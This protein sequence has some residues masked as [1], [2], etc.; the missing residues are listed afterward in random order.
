[1][2]AIK[3]TKLEKFAVLSGV[4]TALI[5]LVSLFGWLTGLRFLTSL[6]VNFIPISLIS[7]VAFFL[8]GIILVCLAGKIFSD[9]LHYIISALLFMVLMCGLVILFGIS[10]KLFP[11]PE[12]K[13]RLSGIVFIVNSVAFL[14]INRIRGNKY[15]NDFISMAGM[16]TAFIGFAVI[17][18]CLFDSPIMYSGETFPISLNRGLCDLFLGLGMI[19]LGGDKTLILKHLSGDGVNA[20]I[21][22]IIIPFA[23]FGVVI[24]SILFILIKQTNLDFA[25]TAAFEIVIFV[26]ICIYLG[27]WL[28]RK[29]FIDAE[30]AEKEKKLALE[31]LHSAEDKYLRIFNVSPVP[32]MITRMKDGRFIDVN[33]ATAELMGLKKEY[34]IGKTSLELGVYA[35]PEDRRKIVEQ[36][37]KS[38]SAFGVEVRQKIPNGREILLRQNYQVFELEGEKCILTISEDIT[39]T[40]KTE[41][42]I[43]RLNADLEQRNLWLEELNEMTSGIN[44]LTPGSD[45][46]E[47]VTGKLIER[48]E[49]G[50]VLFSSYDAGKKTLIVS[51]YKFR[52]SGMLETVIKIL[53]NKPNEVVT[54]VSDEQYKIITG[55]TVVKHDS[56]TELSFGGV[57]S[58]VS[59]GIKK[60]LGLDCFITLACFNDNELFGCSI[61][62]IKTGSE[63]PSVS[64][65]EALANIIAVALRRERAQKA[66]IE[67]EKKYRTLV[68]TTPG[69]IWSIDADARTMFVNES[70]ANMLGYQ[71][72]EML[73]K[74]LYDFMDEE[75]RKLAKIHM[76]RRIHGIREQHD[77]EFTRKDG[78]KIYTSLESTPLKDEKGK[79]IGALAVVT[80]LTIRKSLEGKLIQAQKLDAI[81]QLASGVSH[82]FNNLLTIISLAMEEAKRKNTLE[83]Y[84]K[85]SETVIK[86]SKQA[87]LIAKRLNEFAKKRA[88][89]YR[90]QTVVSIVDYV[91]ELLGN[92]SMKKN[93]VVEKE[94]L[95]NEE[96]YIDEALLVQVVLNLMQNAIHAVK[97]GGV[98]KVLV[99]ENNG[100]ILISVIDNGIGIPKENIPKLFDP[101]FTTKGAFGAGT[102]TGTGLG[103]SVS[104]S[105]MQSL[106]GNISAES[107]EGKGSSFTMS[108]PSLKKYEPALM[109]SKAVAENIKKENKKV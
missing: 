103:L 108:F 56:L 40:K 81:G 3:M 77:F 37:A 42:R 88:I 86:T 85:I 31:V 97:N 100:E 102:E 32:V 106:S 65:L 11:F 63:I 29:I 4:I 105:I 60:L 70:M 21:Q 14:L 46:R 9:K 12:N 96:V 78:S 62:G 17:L 55:K 2:A 13:S 99:S 48:P 79:F 16:F 44:A 109:K 10:I 24:Q 50:V 19:A 75:A 98:I 23:I 28:T 76:E 71:V 41:H 15:V 72:E 61:L 53:G 80:D 57:P 90:K 87:A 82:E 38:G 8:L 30:K 67:N 69:G 92:Q 95:F 52:N 54:C 104:Y 35:D 107:E 1:M 7:A 26:I 59:A 94:Y 68:E 89:T 51:N 66:V 91:L 18:G 22:R 33:T 83:F 36:L 93:L 73:G 43:F 39:E 74:C 45:I 47:Y 27:T 6:G 101:F 20:K 49:I 64:Y 34:I 25:V 5:G 58:I 84:S